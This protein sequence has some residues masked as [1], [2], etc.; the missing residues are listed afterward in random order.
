[1]KCC[2][3]RQQIDRVAAA[4]DHAVAHRIAAP[5]AAAAIEHVGIIVRVFRF[6]KR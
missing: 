1:M 2:S 3:F 6:D 5:S 4:A